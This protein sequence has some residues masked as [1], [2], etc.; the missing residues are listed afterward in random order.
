MTT[1]K[2]WIYAS[3]PRT[4]AGAVAPVA[5]ALM[6]AWRHGGASAFIWQAAVLCLLFALLMQI[7]ANFINDYYDCKRGRDGDGRLGP[8]RACAQGWIAPEAMW[9]GIVITTVLSCL[10]GLPLIVY[11]GWRLVVVGVACVVAAFLYTTLLAQHAMGDL[12]VIVFFGLVPVCAT[13]YVQLSIVPTCI[14]LLGLSVGLATE[15][16]LLVNN[17]RDRHE[18]ER[19]GKRTLVVIIGERAT[20]VLYA[21]CGICAVLLAIPL[22]DKWYLVSF[23]LIPHLATA[24]NMYSIHHGRQLNAMLAQTSFNI[25]IFALLTIISISL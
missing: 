11:G 4:L 1:I 13:Y 15:C 25:L 22:T 17:F 16:L 7:D 9:R 24:Y 10:S 2:A 3:R 5:V 14:F 18:D 12:L 19:C 23:Y 21:L 20:L 8:E 6:A